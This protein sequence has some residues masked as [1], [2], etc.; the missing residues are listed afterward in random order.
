MS[1]PKEITV[2][3]QSKPSDLSTAASGASWPSRSLNGIAPT[4]EVETRM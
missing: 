4:A 3:P 2:A 1:A